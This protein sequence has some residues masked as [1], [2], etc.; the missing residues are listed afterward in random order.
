[1]ATP[2]IDVQTISESDAATLA[3]LRLAFWSDQISKGTI[4]HPEIED[5][6][7]LAD[8]AAL[9]KRARTTILVAIEHDKIVGYVLGQTRV[10]PGVGGSI[11]SSIEEIFVEPDY[12]RFAVARSLVDGIIASFKVM[13]A[14]RIQLRVLENNSEAKKF[15]H[16]MG[17]CP[18]VTLFEYIK[19]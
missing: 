9:I 14:K 5:V 13:D 1:M 19:H 2:A 16:S 4:D 3:S 11:V 8:T 18:A 10:L 15:W 12:R 17:F 6:R 7:L